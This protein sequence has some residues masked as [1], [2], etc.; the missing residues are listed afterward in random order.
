M[1]IHVQAALVRAIRAF[2]VAFIA[3]DPASNLIGAASGS[4]PVDVGALRAAAVG[5]LVA[6]GAFVWRAWVDRLPVPTLVDPDQKHAPA[7]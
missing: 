3:I 5:G 4:Q 6:L 7:K 1:S 2:V